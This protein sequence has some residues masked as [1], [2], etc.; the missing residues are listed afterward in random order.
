[1][2]YTLNDSSQ[3]LE[4]KLQLQSVSDSLNYLFTQFDSLTQE[5]ANQFLAVLKQ[6]QQTNQPLAKLIDMLT[7]NNENQEKLTIL[8]KVYDNLENK[9]IIAK[10]TS[11][12]T[13]TNDNAHVI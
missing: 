2:I 7:I 5:D 6:I 1:M 9:E 11:Y 4:E 8:K 12:Q 13:D 3:V 10:K